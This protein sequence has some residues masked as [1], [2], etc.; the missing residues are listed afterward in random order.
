[1]IHLHL[2]MYFKVDIKQAE[3][4]SKALAD[5]TRL[6]ILLDM[7]K[8]SGNI[9][10]SEIMSNIKLAQPSVS[11]HIKTLI[12]AGLI[13]AEKEGRN[14][15]YYLNQTLLKAYACWISKVAVG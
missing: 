12:E 5:T 15:S 3:K 9:Q 14:H 11:H 8:R 2:S 10:C 7:R 13:V 6:Q 4:I 1:L